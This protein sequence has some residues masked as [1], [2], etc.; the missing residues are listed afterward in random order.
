MRKLAVFLF[1]VLAVGAFFAY[2]ILSR[3][4]RSRIAESRGDA[5]IAEL[6]ADYATLGK[7]CQGEDT[8]GDGYVSCDFRIMN[9]SQNERIVHLQCPTI[10]KT[11]LGGSCKEARAVISTQ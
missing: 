10:W 5:F 11:L 1:V 8:D 6:Y 7:S 9:A 4:V 3:E 2:A